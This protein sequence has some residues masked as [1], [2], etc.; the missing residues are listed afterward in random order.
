MIATSRA[1]CEG[2]GNV[3]VLEMDWAHLTDQIK[4]GTFDFVLVKNVMH[5]VGDV[6]TNLSIL[7]T[8][9]SLTG[10]ILLI[11]TVSP[12]NDSKKFIYELS[13]M[14]ELMGLKKHIFTSRELVG[15][16]RHASL[17]IQKVQ[18]ENQFIELKKWLDAKSRSSQISGQ[19]LAYLQNEMSSDQLRKSMKFEPPSHSFPGRMLRRQMLIQC[20]PDRD[21]EAISG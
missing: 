12:N 19:V 3:S 10:R 11:E 18:Y 21:A 13:R 17:E 9:L 6:V 15:L 14:L 4:P 2:L 8:I 20:V 16:V 5:L 1:K 7:P